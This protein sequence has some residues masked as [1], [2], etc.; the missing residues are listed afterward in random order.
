MFVVRVKKRLVWRVT[1]F[2]LIVMRKRRN[3]LMI[4]FTVLLLFRGFAIRNVCI[5]PCGVLRLVRLGLIFGLRVIR[6][7]CPVVSVR[8]GRVAKGGA[9]FRTLICKLLLLV[10][11]SEFWSSAYVRSLY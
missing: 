3:G 4:W 8:L 2:C 1:L 11:I 6:V 10:L 7:F 5:G 9:I